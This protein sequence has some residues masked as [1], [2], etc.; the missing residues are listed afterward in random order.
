MNAVTT[1]NPWAQ[2]SRIKAIVGHY[3]S[4]KTEIALAMALS[5]RAQGYETCVVDMD[6][7]NPFFR[8]AEQHAFLSER[9]IE[10]IYP[11]YALSGVD[12]PVLP[13]EVYS[14][15]SR[16]NLRAVLDVGGED[17]G[18]AALG[19]Y[20]AQFDR[21]PPQ[22]F[23]VVNLFRP[24]SLTLEQI[25][26]LFDR[27]ERRS[28]LRPD[29]LINNANLGGWT[30]PEQLLEGQRVLESVCAKLGVPIAAICGEARV[31]DALPASLTTPR[32]PIK[33]LLKP[34]WMEN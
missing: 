19:A 15:F 16:P 7:V 4:G 13:P 17:A 12:V 30:E 32:F 22:V 23:Y 11:P 9:G 31:L 14:I 8:S 25:T 28:R 34:E 26:E 2:G 18:A 6:I 10:S 1:F 5:A 21:Q 3:G 33:R 27:I 29:A 20:K 24:F